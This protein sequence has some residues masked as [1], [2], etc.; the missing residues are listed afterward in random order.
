ML[1]VVQCAR[2][3]SKFEWS[4]QNVPGRITAIDFFNARFCSRCRHGGADHQETGKCPR[5]ANKFVKLWPMRWGQI[6]TGGDESICIPETRR[7][8]VL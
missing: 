2:E 6:I 3:E 8:C 1:L 7:K 5:L 4:I